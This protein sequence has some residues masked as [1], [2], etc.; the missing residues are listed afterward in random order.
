MPDGCEVA[1]WR[2]TVDGISEV[3]HAR[4]VDYGYPVHYHDTW[5]VLI[6]DGGAIRYDLDKRA[7]GASG[8]VVAVLPPGV[9]HNGEPAPG[10]Q[11]FTKRVL[12]LDQALIP[13][14]LV[15]AAVEQTNI[16]D[17]GLRST[18]AG[19]HDQLRAGELLQAESSLSLVTE[20]L[21]GHLVGDPSGVSADEPQIARKLRLLLDE[22]P[23][24][25]FS[26]NDAAD[27]L[28]RSKA[29]LVRSFSAAYG[30][31]PHAYLIARQ[32]ET[33]RQLL[34]AG[35]PPADVAATSGFYDQAHLTRHFKRH[36]L[37][38]PAAYQRSGPSE[39][40]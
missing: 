30:I 7:C 36:T 12:Y 9:A 34:L 14:D 25:G 2:P 24:G 15:G 27:T 17:F 26:L 3:F 31:A 35:T 10:A 8:D 21:I 32:V 40:T 39:T 6:V 1:A 29:H 20:R 4:V 5:T 33:A 22:H 23:A 13:I 16:D 19:L 38:T 18:I 28:D 37:L 11:G